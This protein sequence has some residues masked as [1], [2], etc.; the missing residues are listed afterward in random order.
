MIVSAAFVEPPPA[1]PKTKKK[2]RGRPS[3]GKKSN[4]ATEAPQATNSKTRAGRKAADAAKTDAALDQAQSGPSGG[5]SFPT[6]FY[7]E[8]YVLGYQ[9]PWTPQSFYDQ[10]CCLF[11]KVSTV[12]LMFILIS[13]YIL[14][15]GFYSPD[16][17]HPRYLHTLSCYTVN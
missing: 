7:F 2:G 9:P 3:K 1:S 4:E 13:I 10:M 15:N 17:S 5:V 14:I 6:P 8:T 16:S 11:V 12:Q